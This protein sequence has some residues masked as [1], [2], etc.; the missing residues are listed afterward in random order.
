MNKEHIIFIMFWAT[1][2][3]AKRKLFGSLF[4]LFKTEPDKK[5]D[6][7]SIWR[8]DFTNE[9]FKDY[10]KKETESFIIQDDKWRQ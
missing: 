4:N 3:L 9:T 6:I 5:I 7:I 10:I 8:R 2:D 1:G